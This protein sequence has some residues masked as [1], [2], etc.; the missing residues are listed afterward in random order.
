M[1]IRRPCEL[2]NLDGLLLPGGESTAISKLLRSSGIYSALKN[3]LDEGMAVFATCAGAILLANEAA[4]GLGDQCQFSAI[5]ISVVRNAYGPQIESFETLLNISSI[6]SEPF[7]GIFIR[8]PIIEKV[9]SRVEVL[10]SHN[11]NPV[12]CRQGNILAATFHPE[13]TDDVRIH[14]LFLDAIIKNR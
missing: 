1:P 7:Q 14:R 10:A 13:L 3:R 11:K 5:D 12:L 2:Q 9:G 8:S 4:G 6:G